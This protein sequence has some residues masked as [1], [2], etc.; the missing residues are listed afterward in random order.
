MSTSSD[1]FILVV[2]SKP[3]VYDSLSDAIKM[4]LH[5]IDICPNAYQYQDTANHERLA[6]QIN[7]TGKLSFY[8]F[9]DY[10]D[11]TAIAL[12]KSALP[13]NENDWYNMAAKENSKNRLALQSIEAGLQERNRIN[14]I[15]K[16]LALG[17]FI[18]LS[19]GRS[20]RVMVINS[21][22]I[23]VDFTSDSR[24]FPIATNGSVSGSCGMQGDLFIRPVPSSL[25][26]ADSRMG[27]YWMQGAGWSGQGGKLLDIYAKTNVWQVYALNSFY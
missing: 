13:Y 21:D 10:N 19:D 11:P 15:N 25:R 23:Q 1:I 6:A 12:Y 14:A 2:K 3:T 17:D 7:E 20:G 27:D 9:T 26:Q 18:D 4:Y 16:E 8:A 24:T 22:T 5:H